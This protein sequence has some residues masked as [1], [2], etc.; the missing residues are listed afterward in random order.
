MVY[1]R[2]RNYAARRRRMGRYAILR[3][4]M[5]GYRPLFQRTGLSVGR[6]NN[7]IHYFKRTYSMSNAVGLSIGGVLTKTTNALIHTT[8]VGAL[9]TEYSS[10]AFYFQLNDVVNATEFTLLFDKYRPLGVVVKLVPFWG[11]SESAAA[12]AGYAQPTAI[13]HSVIDYDDAS[14]PT[15]SEAGVDTLRQYAN[16]KMRH[17]SGMK[18]LRRFWRPKA[19]IATYSGTFT[20]YAQESRAV[21]WF[22]M[23]S[24]NVQFYSYKGI[25]ETNPCG[26]AQQLYIKAEATVYL[27]LKDI[28]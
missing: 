17:L 7:P 24:P 28:R 20:S 15:A 21:L 12:G 8:T 3:K 22:D 10:F 11:T 14:T 6:Y 18:P 25:I 23:N 13:L 16:Y 2:T 4:R 5:H 9:T 19:A 26:L 27:A 1:R